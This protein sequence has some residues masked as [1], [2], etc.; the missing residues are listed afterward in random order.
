MYFKD[1]YKKAA[2][3]LTPDK[4][5]ID[6]MRSAVLREISCRKVFPFR[7]IAIVG[8][9]VAACAV[10][11]VAAFTVIPVLRNRELVSYI[12]G[13][14]GMSF[15]SA[16]SI[17]ES[18]SD[19]AAPA[20][21]EAG[22]SSSVNEDARCEES[23]LD[24]V[25]EN[26]PSAG[27]PG[28]VGACAAPGAADTASSG[29]AA[30]MEE[31]TGA[32]ETA[33]AEAPVQPETN[34]SFGDNRPD[35]ET[36]YLPETYA[37]SDEASSEEYPYFGDHPPDA[38]IVTGEMAESEEDGVISHGITSV[39]GE[40]SSEAVSEEFSVESEELSEETTVEGS[41]ITDETGEMST[42]AMETA[43]LEAMEGCDIITME[44]LFGESATSLR[45][46]GNYAKLM[47]GEDTVITYKRTANTENV[48]ERG[49]EVAN[50][51][52]WD[53]KYFVRAD[54]SRLIYIYNGN[55][56][57]FIGAYKRAD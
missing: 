13:G 30:S 11:T 15:D 43:P 6:R 31:S 7:R 3:D 24:E 50:Y 38:D 10:I 52:E 18:S 2:E 28:N 1:E 47:N 22:L 14:N 32:P 54:D 41:C 36:G 34:A 46:S 45:V 9:A 51:Y 17:S 25:K 57:E 39:T 16:A 12:S 56:G 5:C 40:P 20:D 42:Q 33:S 55:S 37:V 48:P 21:H 19:N 23:A 8:G 26:E 49:A 35:P 27:A 44:E 4:A 53:N 29:I